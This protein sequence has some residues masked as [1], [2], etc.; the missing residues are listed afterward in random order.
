MRGD[1]GH[2]NGGCPVPTA[3]IGDGRAS[4]ELV[5][6]L[7]SAGSQ[8]RDKVGVVDGPEESFAP[9]VY[10]LDVVMPADAGA[11]LGR[12]GDPGRVVQRAEGHL[13]DPGQVGGA[14]V[15]GSSFL[16][17]NRSQSNDRTI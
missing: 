7:S 14:V 2:Q 4:L 1:L 5:H 11:G 9:L 15:I 13:E 12:F 16:G 3:N 6:E 17:M 8:A 10:V